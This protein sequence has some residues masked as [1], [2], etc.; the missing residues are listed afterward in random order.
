VLLLG[1]VN[2]KKRGQLV[3][4][5]AYAAGVPI[6]ADGVFEWVWT[7]MMRYL[8]L[9]LEP[10]CVSL[11]CSTEYPVLPAQKKRKIRHPDQIA[12]LPPDSVVVGDPDDGAVSMHHTP[13][14][15]QI[16][17]AARNL[18]LCFRAQKVY[19]KPILEGDGTLGDGNLG[20]S[21]CKL[22]SDKD[23]DEE[24]Q[25]SIDPGD[26]ER[27]GCKP[28]TAKRLAVSLLQEGD[29]EDETDDDGSGEDDETH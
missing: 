28:D 5:L 26:L 16:E 12:K 9:L 7:R 15:A 27:Y 2:V 10:A 4:R 18:Q 20:A 8:S 17:D 3:R 21:G 1:L 25:G 23:S 24:A 29:S 13:V 6:I 11:V 14:P 22:E 19:Q